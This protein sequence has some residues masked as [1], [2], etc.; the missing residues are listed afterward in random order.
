MKGAR[1]L[2]AAVAAAALIAAPLSASTTR[3][4]APG[5]GA[6]AKVAD[7]ADLL[8]VVAGD[9]RPT[10]R[11]A[12]L[13]RVARQI[14]SE[15]GLIRPDFVLW[16]GDVVYGY[17]D[18]PRELSAEYVRFLEAARAAAAPVYDAPGN[19]EIHHRDGEPCED[20]ASEREF[21]QRFGNLYGSFDAGGAHFIALDTAQVCAEDRLDADQRA[22]LARDL[23]ANR[24]AR[25]IFVFTH[26]EF[27]SSPTIDPDA[28]KGHPPIQD[29]EGLISLFRRYPVRAVFCGHE[30]VYSHE[31]SQGIDFFIA[32]GAGAPLY[33]SPD[34][35]G[36]SHYVVLR[37]T[38]GELTW[39]LV[40]PGRLYVETGKDL[41]GAPTTWIVNSNDADV[42]LRGV[43]LDAPGRLGPCAALEPVTRVVKRDGSTEPVA[44]AVAGCGVESG[45]RRVRVTLTSPRGTSV[46]VAVGRSKAKS[47]VE[48]PPREQ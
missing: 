6:P 21:A 38:G 19:H 39:D 31:T 17:G 48:A 37:L 14:F 35:G 9:S 26:T 27:F 1:R 28:G 13:P 11:D 44:A 25:A 18:S 12:P 23:E 29:R 15:I 22:W 5:A 4:I 34:R 16:T 3:P 47:P 2:P 36:F 33:A 43:W 32:G 7:G 10:G 41:A 45:R 40:E 42:P 24:N 20:R 46:R 30:H 8:F